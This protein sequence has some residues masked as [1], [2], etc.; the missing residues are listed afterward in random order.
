MSGTD[1]APHPEHQ[2]KPDD[3]TDLTKPSWTYIL[4]KTVREFQADRCTDIAAALTYYA[5]LSLFPAAI[6]LLSLVACSARGR[7]RSTRW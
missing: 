4:R 6:A 2:A 3:P 5:V 1:T 7:S